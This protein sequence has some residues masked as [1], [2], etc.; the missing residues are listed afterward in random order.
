METNLFKPRKDR[1]LLKRILLFVVIG[2]G[3]I[4]MTSC[5]YKWIR[6]Q[7]STDQDNVCMNRM[8]CEPGCG[9]DK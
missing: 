6:H 2:L 9:H 3:I 5:G 7:A 4:S 1:G 8:Y